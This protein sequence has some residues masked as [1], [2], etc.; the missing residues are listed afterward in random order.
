MALRRKELLE[1]V[2]P[3]LL[4]YLRD[5]AATMVTDKATSVTV[6]DILASA[7]GDLQP[8]MTAVA[9]L[10]NQELLPGGISGQVRRESEQDYECDLRSV[11]SE[12]VDC[13]A[14]RL[15]FFSAAASHG[16]ASSRTPGAEMAHRA[17]HDTSRGWQ[18]R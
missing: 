16:R 5:N 15:N 12:V 9:Q 18:R 7:C 2:S 11:S 14:S 13:W 3:P 6:S 4:E 1:V 8:A 17:G 10:A